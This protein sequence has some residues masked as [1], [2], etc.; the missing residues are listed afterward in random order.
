MK[1]L[2]RR[3]LSRIFT[4][5][6][7]LAVGAGAFAT[8]KKL[9]PAGRAAPSLLAADLPQPPAQ[10]PTPPPPPPTPQ[11]TQPPKR[12]VRA[13]KLLAL[14]NPTTLP[15]AAAHA[16]TIAQP[17]LTLSDNPLGDAK[18]AFDSGDP[19]LARRI[20]GEALAAGKIK[21]SGIDSATQL[22]AAASK[23]IIFG[24][25]IY[26]D[27]PYSVAYTVQPGEKLQKIATPYDINWQLVAR[28]NGIADAR[29]LRMYQRLK[30][31]RGP[32]HAV[33][34][35]SQFNIELYLGAPGGPGSLLVMRMPVG[36][37]K[38]DS[39]PTGKWLAGHRVPNPVWFG[40][41]GEGEVPPGDPKNPLGKYWI[42]LVGVD[43]QASGQQSYG[44]HGTN[45]PASIGKQESMGCIRLRNDDIA[46]VFDLL[47]EGK[48]IVV[49][50]D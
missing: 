31:I 3:R 23:E 26:K 46:T 25:R 14:N 20:L 45:D 9:H 30:L 41:R 29:G 40:P 35:K 19:I 17:P 15:A 28:I 43:G 18:T 37:G 12:L 22:L 4:I 6:M 49:V 1:R 10:P 24:R 5:V 50:K 32:F 44:I 42:G 16:P 11:K 47:T 36:L 34:H 7:L 21:G 48:S 38:D 27:D 39:T 33:V 13:P 2:K 8:I